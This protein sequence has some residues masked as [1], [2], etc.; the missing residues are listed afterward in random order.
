MTTGLYQSVNV[1]S[2]LELLGGYKKIY[3]K[4]AEQF[5]ENQRNLVSEIK[6]NLKNDYDLEEAR[7]LVHSCK[8]ISKNLGANQLYEISTKFEVAII[9]QD[10]KMIKQHMKEFKKEF[11]VV[12]SELR[13]VITA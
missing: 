11:K 1:D 8:G 9:D 7:R 4:I 5:L 3:N 10:K 13:K 12:L 2:A 6:F